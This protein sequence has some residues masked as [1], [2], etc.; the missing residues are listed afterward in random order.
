[1]DHWLKESEDRT[2]IEVVKMKPQGRCLKSNSCLQ[3]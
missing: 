1:L 3:R 2:G